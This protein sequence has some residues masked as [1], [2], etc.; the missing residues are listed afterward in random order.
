MIG[1]AMDVS[2]DKDVPVPMRDGTILYADVFRPRK[3]GRYPVLLLRTPY[4][5]ETPLSQ[6]YFHPAKYSMLGYVVIVQD[7]RGRWKSGGDFDPLIAEQNDGYDSVEWAASLPY[8]NGRV[9]TYGFSYAGVTQLY[10]A[11]SRPPSLRAICPGFTAP[12]LREGWLFNG[13]AFALSFAA[14]WAAQLAMHSSRSNRDEAAFSRFLRVYSGE[15]QDWGHLPL[16]SYPPLIGSGDSEMFF[17]WID[18]QHDSLYWDERRVDHR[19]PDMQVPGLHVGGW[20][21]TFL[22]GTVENFTRMSQTTPCSSTAS[23]QKLV[24]GP[25][26]H[27]LW[28]RNVGAA[29]FGPE[30]NNCVNTWQLKWFDQFLRDEDTGV[31]D[32]GAEVF[33][34]GVNRW[35]SFSEWPPS[36]ARAEEFYL[37]GSGSANTAAGDGSLSQEAPGTE[38]PDVFLYDPVFPTPSA[39]GTSWGPTKFVPVGVADQGLVESLPSV[40]CYTTPP[41]EKDVLV[42]GRVTVTLFAATSAEDTDFTAKLC[43][44]DDLDR[45]WNVR[46]GIIRARHKDGLSSSCRVPANSVAQYSID[47]GSVA[48]VFLRGS[49]IRLQISSSS[50]PQWD[51]NL[52]TGGPLGAESVVDAQVATQIVLHDKDHPSRVTL[53]MVHA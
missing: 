49:R 46:E 13:G 4:N 52:N 34:M 39:G 40:L 33:L 2:I 17:K 42:A 45:S 37:H 38:S 22:D 25:W 21:D 12:R 10:A 26:W 43:E 47:L 48:K 44:V 7:V 9:G 28:G 27:G 30:A 23:T 51:R 8:S 31:L 5:K 20:F 50:F 19:Y 32:G 35:E 11:A 14:T 16:N 41:L 36:E 15:G 53:P 3:F 1:R 24:V 18:H 29:D 6:T